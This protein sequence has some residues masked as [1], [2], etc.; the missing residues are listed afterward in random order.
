MN[1]SSHGRYNRPLTGALLGFASMTFFSWQD[2]LIKLLSTQYSLFQILFLRSGVII[3]P[4]FFILI[5]RYGIRAFSTNRPLDHG[6][7]VA[8]NFVAFLSYYF[9]ISRLELG[10]AT[11]IALSAPLF[12]TALS[13]PLLGEPADLKRKGVLGVGF[14]G[15]ILVIQPDFAA[16]DWLG[17]GAALF[18]ALMF[19]MLG[20][21]TRSMSATESTE[22]MV[23]FGGLTFLVV[24]GLVMLE[25]WITPTSG[26]LVL[27]L[28]VG[29]ITLIAQLLIVHSYQFAAVYVIAP[30]EYVTILWA[31]L[32]GWL[33]FAEIPTA[34]MLV[35]CAVVVACG[36]AIV[37][38]EHRLDPPGKI[39][40]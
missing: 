8:Y 2:A 9:A 14:L 32:L 40:H 13:G 34:M 23:F 12:M 29:A 30:F 33:F 24:T 6:I 3:V 25:S 10:Q 1:S 31:I 22:L 11:A 7:R 20:I 4:L 27:L 39:A 37:H 5:F 18:G 19:A 17:T 36:L 38:L 28:G 35:G 16:T 21:K 26:D 15:V